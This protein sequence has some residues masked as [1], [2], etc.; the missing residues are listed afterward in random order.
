MCIC[1]VEAHI[2]MIRGTGELTQ[3]V[4]DLPYKYEDLRSLE[5]SMDRVMHIC[6]HSIPTVRR[7]VEIRDFS[8][9]LGPAR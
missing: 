8:D 2:R 9:T 6:N 1:L 3:R 7:N 5:A 4:K